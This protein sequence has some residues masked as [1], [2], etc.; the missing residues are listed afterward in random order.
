MRKFSY[1]QSFGSQFSGWTPCGLLV[2]I[3]ERQSDQHEG[4]L[5]LALAVQIG[6][7]VGGEETE[8]RNVAELEKL[9]VGA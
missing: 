6:Q 1:S 9:Q 8:F 7:H 4:S 3:I 2:V 5:L